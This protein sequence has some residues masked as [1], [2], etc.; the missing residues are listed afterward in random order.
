M[1][2]VFIICALAALAVPQAHALQDDDLNDSLL[3]TDTA[4]TDYAP[5]EDEA[6][7]P[8]IQESDED[9]AGFIQ[10][11]VKKDTALKGSFFIEDPAARKVLKLSLA[12]AP[13]K[14]SA[15]PDNT[16]VME[17]VF[18]DTAGKRYS[19]LF[20]IQSAGFG[21][22]DIFKIELKTGPKPVQEDEPKKKKEEKKIPPPKEIMQKIKMFF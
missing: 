18:K 12:T 6:A 16:K 22:I 11:Y 7:Q 10:D 21:G 14:S 20:H 17:A 13:K 8:Y 19:V 1:K 2:T 4:K 15:G 9:L 5:E 3:S